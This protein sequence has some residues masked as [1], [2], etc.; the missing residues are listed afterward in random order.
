[1]LKS[2]FDT[3]PD[4]IE[5]AARWMAST[6]CK[7]SSASPCRWRCRADIRVRLLLYGGVE[8]LSVWSIFLSSASNFTLPVGLNALS[9][10]QITSGDG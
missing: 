3:I 1:M 4:E 7:L 2:Y 10:R 6:V 8:R 5:E 9:V